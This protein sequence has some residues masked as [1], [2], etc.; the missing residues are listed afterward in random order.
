MKRLA[1]RAPNVDMF[2]SGYVT[3]DASGWQITDLGR[4]FLKSIEAPAPEPVL[5]KP[6]VLGL[7]FASNVI[8]L[9]DHKTLRRRRVAA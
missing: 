2:S 8:R 1:A 5:L 9:A 4:A 3:R 6:A 7:D